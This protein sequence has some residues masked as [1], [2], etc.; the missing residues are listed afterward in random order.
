ML[1]EETK[2][3]DQTVLKEDVQE[4]PVESGFEEET[5]DMEVEDDNV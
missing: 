1:V 3:E 2:R 5:K 4:M